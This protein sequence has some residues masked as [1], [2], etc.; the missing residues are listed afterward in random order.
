MSVMS[1]YSP[2]RGPYTIEDLDAMPEEGK[3]HEL[4][5]GWLI[6]MA[7]SVVHDLVAERV[8][9]ILASSVP[10][11]FVVYGPWD[12]LMPDDSIYKPDVAVLDESALLDAA[13]DDRRAVTG[14]D[15]LLAVEV[16]RPR[17][18]SWKTVHNV[19]VRDYALAGV[20]Y[21]WI[22]DLEDGPELTVHAL[23]PD[24]T[25][26]RTHHVTG[27]TVVELEKPFPVKFA[28]AQLLG[29]RKPEE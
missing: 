24:G 20:P 6:E 10:Q 13:D 26:A 14:H 16:Q 28:P 8:K 1:D 4:I 17:S 3:R 19:K 23:G 18:G 21:Y 22:I 12:V 25:Y 27:G 2:D 29:W 11:G 5:H 9:A 7:A 15:V